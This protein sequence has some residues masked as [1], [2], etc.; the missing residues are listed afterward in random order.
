MFSLVPERETTGVIVSRA[1]R[2]DG[3][4]KRQSARTAVSFCV[5]ETRHTKPHL[6][7]CEEK[8]YLNIFGGT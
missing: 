7:Y 8:V 1:S 4:A 5:F 3:R 2:A 6:Y